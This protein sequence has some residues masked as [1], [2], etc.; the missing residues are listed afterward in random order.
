VGEQTDALDAFHS[1]RVAERILGFGDVM[2]IIER[3]EQA[4]SQEDA[5]QMQSSLTSGQMDFNTM[6]Q[7]FQMVKKMGNLKSL[8]KMIPGLSAQI[9]DEA[10]DQLNEGQMGQIEAIILSMTPK[11]RSNPDI[12]NGSRRKRIAAGSG[13]T[14]EDVNRLV[15]Q[16]YNMRRQMKEF[17]KVSKRMKK[18]KRR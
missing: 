14:V 16:L 6:L 18:F 13:R 8:M 11:E 10:L 7:Q 4:F 3:A 1:Q 2:G 9:P 12:I 17:S 5:E 15:S